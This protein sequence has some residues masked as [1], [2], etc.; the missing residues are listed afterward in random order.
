MG[1]LAAN[2]G[3]ED[4]FYLRTFIIDRKATGKF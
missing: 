1:L 3:T 4:S 2:Q